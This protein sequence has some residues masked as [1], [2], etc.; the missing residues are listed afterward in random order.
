MEKKKQQR[1]KQR[2]KKGTK[3][4]AELTALIFFGVTTLTSTREEN[5]FSSRFF[6]TCCHSERSRGIP[7]QNF[8]SILRDPSTPLRFAQDDKIRFPSCTLYCLC[9]VMLPDEAVPRCSGERRPRRREII[10]RKFS[11]APAC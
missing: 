6:C 4:N 2:R 3:P 9:D 10:V 11:T 5:L 7:Q 8:N 1:K